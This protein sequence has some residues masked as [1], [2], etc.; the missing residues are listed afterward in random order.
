VNILVAED[1]LVSRRLLAVTLERWGYDVRTADDGD[2]AWDALHA[3]DAPPLAILDWMMPG[4]EGPDLCRR[5]RAEHASRPLYVIL[6]TAKNRPAEVAAGLS[7]GADDYIVKP[8]E[9]E[10][11]HARVQ[12]GV[13]VVELQRGILESARELREREEHIRAI[14][15]HAK[16][17][18]LTIDEEGIIRSFNPSAGRIFGVAAADAIGRGVSILMPGLVPA[19]LAPEGI[20]TG[21]YREVEARRS[22]GTVIPVELAVS[23]VDRG[24]SSHYAAIVRDVGE[25]KRAELELRHAQKLESVG[26]LAAGIAHEI[27]TP[28]QFVGDNLRFLSK[29]FSSFMGV[30]AQYRGA[31]AA[32]GAIPDDVRRE[33]RAAEEEADLAYLETEVPRATDQALEGVGRVAK[34]VRAMKEFA[35]PDQPEKAPV[36]LNQALRSTLTVARNEIKYF[37]DVETDMD[38]LPAVSCHAGDLNQVFL[39]LFVNAA[40]A[41]ADVVKNTGEK[42]RIRVRTRREGDEAVIAIS[43]TGAGI[44]EDIRTRIFDPFFTTKEIGRGTGQGLAIARAVVTQKHGGTLTFES[45]V[46]HGTTFTIRLP[47]N[48]GPQTPEEA[49]A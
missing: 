9:R 28:I 38:D 18:I 8:F 11:L 37:A 42:G 20:E 21:R 39:N 22:D 16:D 15:D 47:I 48:G 1:D 24:T 5:L 17:G 14:V 35:H 49:T 46:G 13:R 29:S 32:S 45:E 6:L 7:A 43:D 27:N 10:E 31:C 34:I 26:R 19:S 2:V 23:R 30:V 36:D 41:I 3:P 33:L 25:R 4:I 40:H 44:P 12:V